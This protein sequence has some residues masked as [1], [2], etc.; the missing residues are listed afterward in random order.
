MI[1]D[2]FERTVRIRIKINDGQFRMKDG[3]ALPTFAKET[4]GELVV[5]AFAI[6]DDATRA[7]LTGENNVRFL[8]KGFALYARLKGEGI[9]GNLQKRV[10]PWKISS[11]QQG[12]F[13]RFELLEDLWITLRTGKRGQLQDCPV[14]VFALNTTAE[15]VNE[16]YT[17][18]SVAFEPSRRSHSGNVFRCVYVESTGGILEPLEKIRVSVEA[19]PPT[20]EELRLR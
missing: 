20:A 4:E 8:P 5:P 19:N 1:P 15:S 7:R 2:P 18:I 10:E 16:A 13:V 3:S 17:K 14:N 11:G 12:V 6:V 9:P